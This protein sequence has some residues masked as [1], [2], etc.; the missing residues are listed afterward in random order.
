MA[1]ASST[2]LKAITVWNIENGP[3]K[4]T[5]G[6]NTSAGPQDF[7]VL[8]IRQLA[9]AMTVQR[10]YSKA[11]GIRVLVALV[12]PLAETP[13]RRCLSDVTEGDPACRRRLHHKKQ[14]R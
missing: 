4:I 13:L 9:L 6:T 11:L 2:E 7:L 10:W 8:V 3:V 1:S 14:A 12:T 5:V